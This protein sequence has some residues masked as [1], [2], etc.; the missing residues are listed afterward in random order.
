MEN[1]KY[2]EQK[3]SMMNVEDPRQKTRNS[4]KIN[5]IQPK[6]KM[7]LLTVV[8]CGIILEC[9]TLTLTSKCETETDAHS[10]LKRLLMKITDTPLF[11]TDLPF[12]L[13]NYSVQLRND[14]QSACNTR[15][16]IQMEHSDKRVNICTYQGH[17]RIDVRQFLNDKATMK[18]IF[19]NVR[20]FL[21]LNV[22]FPFIQSEV[23]RQLSEL[24]S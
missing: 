7:L 20:K 9:A 4:S 15:R 3:I 19:F 24:S 18:G 11:Q 1:K 12:T 2:T 17:V 14:S 22:I 5:R 10:S 6:L 21:S 16:E 23:N 8:V 13:Y